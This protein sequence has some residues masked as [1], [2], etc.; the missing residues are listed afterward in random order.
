MMD[1][2]EIEALADRT[3]DA[4]SYEDYGRD[5]WVRCITFLAEKGF[6]AREIEDVLRSKVMRRAA[7]EADEA[8]FAA[9][10][11][12]SLTPNGAEVLEGF[13]TSPASESPEGGPHTLPTTAT[14]EERLKSRNPA[15]RFGVVKENPGPG[16]L[17]VNELSSFDAGSSPEDGDYASAALITSMCNDG[18]FSKLAFIYDLAEVDPEAPDSHADDS[19]ARASATVERMLEA[20]LLIERDGKIFT[21]IELVRR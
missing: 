10:E 16:E 20:G 6:G 12:Y 21:N 17:T 13:K 2:K 4:Y 9:L 1:G 3:A 8:S 15:G 18:R 19:I 11:A 7:D 14:L 5:A